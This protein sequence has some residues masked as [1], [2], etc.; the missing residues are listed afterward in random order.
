MNRIYTDKDYKKCTHSRKLCHRHYRFCF[1]KI[2]VFL[3]SDMTNI[4]YTLRNINALKTWEHPMSMVSTSVNDCINPMKR[5][6][7]RLHV[8]CEVFQTSRHISTNS[9]LT[10][11][12]IVIRVELDPSKL[13][14]ANSV[15][16]AV[17][18]YVVVQLLFVWNSRSEEVV[19]V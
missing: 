1:V 4:R 6:P 7:V 2:R 10:G 13:A 14:R 15:S 12:A 9:R 8:V 16:R 19:R 11:E 18:L 17:V 5:L 3:F